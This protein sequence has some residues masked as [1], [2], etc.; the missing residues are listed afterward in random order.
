MLKLPEQM[1]EAK[2]RQGG[3]GGAG[4]GREGGSAGLRSFSPAGKLH[5]SKLHTDDTARN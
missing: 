5:A 2:E 1:Q 4:G 3:G